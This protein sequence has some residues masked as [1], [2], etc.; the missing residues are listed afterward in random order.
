MM[1]DLLLHEPLLWAAIWLLV[2]VLILA[3]P[4]SRPRMRTIVLWALVITG[5]PVL[6]W[7]TWSNGPFFGLGLLIAAALIL[8]WPPLQLWRSWRLQQSE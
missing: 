1:T 5:V 6:G 2:A 4:H 8:R 7:T 3:R